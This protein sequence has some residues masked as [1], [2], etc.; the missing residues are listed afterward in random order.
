MYFSDYANRNIFI[1]A[2]LL[3]HC[4]LF[5]IDKDISFKGSRSYEI[6]QYYITYTEKGTGLRVRQSVCINID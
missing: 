2:P 6:S 5:D 3:R 4:T 1:G